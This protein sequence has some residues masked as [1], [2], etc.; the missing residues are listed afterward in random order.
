M[1]IIMSI[2]PKWAENIYSGEKTIEWRKTCPKYVPTPPLRTYPQPIKV[3]LYETSPV[4]NVTGFF[5]WSGTKNLIIRE[6]EYEGQ[7]IC[8]AAKEVIRMGC[9]PL[10]DLKKYQ[11]TSY[12]L[13]GWICG[14]N[15]KFEKPR[16][17]SDFGLKRPPQSW[18][19]LKE[20]E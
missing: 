8:D 7:E 3:F 5:Y 19:Y 10:E 4:C 2:H 17:L 1:N 13:F 18:Q 15:E 9:V 20:D 11:G 14:L 16:P 12:K 6:P